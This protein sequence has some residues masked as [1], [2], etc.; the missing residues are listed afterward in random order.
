M[1]CAHRLGLTEGKFLRPITKVI[2]LRSPIHSRSPNL[3]RVRFQSCL[4]PEGSSSFAASFLQLRLPCSCNSPP[5]QEAEQHRYQARPYNSV[6]Y[7]LHPP[8]ITL[9]MPLDMPSY[10]PFTALLFG[11]SHLAS[12]KPAQLT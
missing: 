7:R 3:R 4:F 11:V 12:R 9:C 10:H 2:T 5:L 8:D 1:P 6:L